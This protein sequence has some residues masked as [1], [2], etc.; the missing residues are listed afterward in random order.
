MVSAIPRKHAHSL[1]RLHSLAFDCGTYYG[2]S[3]L[4][5]AWVV[6][7]LSRPSRE[8]LPFSPT[9]WADFKT[10]AYA[11]DRASSPLDG[12]LE[13][14]LTPYSQV[15]LRKFMREKCVPPC[16]LILSFINLPRFTDIQFSNLL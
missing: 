8:R 13:E 10:S 11:Q 12:L 14:N 16:S 2:G 6:R 4:S 7:P 15:Y 9:V 1:Q 5:P 3:R